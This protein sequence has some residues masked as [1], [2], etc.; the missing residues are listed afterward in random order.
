MAVSPD[1]KT[2]SGRGEYADLQY[3][4]EVS[5]SAG[6]SEFLLALEDGFVAGDNECFFP[7]RG[8]VPKGMG[9][10]TFD[11]GHGARRSFTEAELAR[12]VVLVIGTPP[13]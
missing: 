11:P 13:P 5:V 1:G 12:P 4:K 6:G 7:F 10:Y 8:S 3:R 9:T 2:C